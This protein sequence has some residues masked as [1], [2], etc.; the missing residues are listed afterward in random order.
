MLS[1]DSPVRKAVQEDLEAAAN[2]SFN[3]P[4]GAVGDASAPG[5]PSTAG[6]GTAEGTPADVVAAGVTPSFDT[7]QIQTLVDQGRFGDA[8]A[9]AGAATAYSAPGNK[10]RGGG[11]QTVNERRRSEIMGQQQF[12]GVDGKQSCS[13]NLK[14]VFQP[15]HT[16]FEEHKEFQ[17]DKGAI[18][19]G[20]Y[21][22]QDVLG[23]AAFSSA[24]RCLD[25]AAEE[26]EDEWVCLKV[27]KNNKDF[28]DQSLDEIKLL[29]Y[30]NSNGDPDEKHV[31]RLIDFFYCQEHL[32][33]VSELLRE[34]LYEFG[35]A[36]REAGQPSYFTIPRLKKITKEC[37]SALDFIHSLNLIHCDVK[38]EN[39]VV[40]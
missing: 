8:S 4:M 7:S 30:I 34:N 25:C 40:K 23:E 39:I 13:F 10:A 6:F 14:I 5:T 33:I 24:L 35:K 19:A 3:T 20:R 1:E 11:R 21:E 12:K 15:F 32:F 22:V 16:G 2:R 9:G 29:Q 28:F 38:P 26:D 17:P 18:I 27:I 31:L 37:L 36:M